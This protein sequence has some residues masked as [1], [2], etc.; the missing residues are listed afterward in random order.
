MTSK[1][2]LLD[3]IGIMCKFISINFMEANTKVSI[4]D[5]KLNIQGPNKIQG[6]LRYIQG[7]G[8]EDI[9]EIFLVIYRIIKWY[10]IP[11]NELLAHNSQKQNKYNANSIDTDEYRVDIRNSDV[12]ILNDQDTESND[13]IVSSIIL[14]DDN[15]KFYNIIRQLAIYMCDG[16][17]TLQTTYATGNVIFALQYYINLLRDALNNN[18][19]DAKLPTIVM[20]HEKKSRNFL[21]YD[22]IRKLWDATKINRLYELY[23]KCFVLKLQNN[24]DDRK[25]NDTLIAGY[26]EAI[27]KLLDVTDEQ[28][29]SL[30][31]YS[32]SG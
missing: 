24:A 5:H 29:R 21:D 18:Y 10:I 2:Q 9:S 25:I 19:S 22:K 17:E 27:N 31:Y 13:N 14:T 11:S 20:D 32:N 26:L 23:E 3:P 15:I 4:K 8:K 16:M 12:N 7:D 28:F 1:K 30:I 6:L